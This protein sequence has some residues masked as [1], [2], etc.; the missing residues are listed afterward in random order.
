MISQ[1]QFPT[2]TKLEICDTLTAKELYHI[3]GKHLASTDHILIIKD[4]TNLPDRDQL[5]FDFC[6]LHERT[7]IEDRVYPDPKTTDLM[8]IIHQ[9]IDSP[10]DLVIGIGGGSVLDAAK[11]VTLLLNNGGNLEDYLVQKRPIQNK[12]IKLALIPTTAGTG[13]EVTQFAVYTCKSGRKMTLKSPL[14]QADLAIIAP[15]MTYRLPPRLTAATGFDALSHALEALWNKNA[16]AQSDQAAIEAAIDI[17][18]WLGIAYDSSSSLAH[19]GR[20]EMM[21]GALKAGLAFNLTGTAAVHALS[22]ILSEEWHIHHGEACAFTLEDI[23]ILNSQ[24]KKTEN[25][26]KRVAAEIFPTKPSEQL[27]LCLFG[28][29]SNLKK[30]MGMPFRFTD[31]KININNEEIPHLFERAFDDPK[32]SNNIITLEKEIIFS[33]LQGQN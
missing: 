16:S 11:A 1:D 4:K 28:Y 25:K 20:K 2:T 31:L 15:S 27:I 10:I 32:M 14:L 17:L 6:Q 3:L 8:K 13:A 5:I 12:G 23:L 33:M 22:F 19:H 29:I 30:R 21:I 7:I 24:D 26:L 9:I 18:K